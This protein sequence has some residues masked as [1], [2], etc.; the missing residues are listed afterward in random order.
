[1]TTFLSLASTATLACPLLL[2]ACGGGGNESGPPDAIQ[3]SPNNVTVTGPIGACA[4]GTGPKVFIYGGT[5]PYKLRNSLPTGM[6]LDRSG[7]QD[8]GQG[9]QITFNGTCMS[10]IPVSVEDDM[11]R[12]AEVMV[13]NELGT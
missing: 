12:I 4:S 7:V 10:S 6:V 5:P 1:M 3:L 2:S 11:G 8:S 9:F 13:S